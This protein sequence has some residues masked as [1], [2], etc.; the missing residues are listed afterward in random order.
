MKVVNLGHAPAQAVD[1]V[2]QRLVNARTSPSTRIQQMRAGF[3]AQVLVEIPD[4]LKLQKG[5]VFKVIGLPPST[6]SKF[7]REQKLLDQS[8][9][10]R[11]D[12]LADVFA[13]ASDTLGDAD[14]AADWLG[15]D[16]FALGGERPIDLLDTALGAEQVRRILGSLRHGGVL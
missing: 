3:P 16:N 1:G 13:L 6:A 9:S 10:E 11:V 8:T 14:H 15:S 5:E 12:R 2:F 4:V 7:I